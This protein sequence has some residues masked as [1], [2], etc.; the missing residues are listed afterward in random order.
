MEDEEICKYFN[1]SSSLGI[2][3]QEMAENEINETPEVY[4][5][6]MALLQSYITG[7]F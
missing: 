3:W 6:E 4:K 7:I 2:K 1:K 5:E